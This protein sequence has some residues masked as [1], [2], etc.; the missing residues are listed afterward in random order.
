MT[1][2]SFLPTSGVGW[3]PI[4]AR[5][6]NVYYIRNQQ[7]LGQLDPSPS[8][9]FLSPCVRITPSIWCKMSP[10]EH[11][12]FPHR[13]VGPDLTLIEAGSSHPQDLVRH[14]KDTKAGL[15]W[16]WGA[17]DQAESGAGLEILPSESRPLPPR[18][19]KCRRY[20]RGS[21]AISIN[22]SLQAL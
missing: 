13:S 2:W 11:V 16:L 7:S 5:E 22:R 18:P 10:R 6:L 12:P 1:P 14:C 20:K 15:R 19:E 9:Q 17:G 21:S 8:S 4:L 3:L